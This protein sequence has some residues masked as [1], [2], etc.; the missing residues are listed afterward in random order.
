ML[1]GRLVGLFVSGPIFWLIYGASLALRS[2]LP[3]P[4]LAALPVPALAFGY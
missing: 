2:P 3:P 1:A 4:I